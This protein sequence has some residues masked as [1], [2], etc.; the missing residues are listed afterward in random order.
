MQSYQHLMCYIIATLPACTLKKNYSNNIT[1]LPKKLGI[2]IQENK[3]AQP[4]CMQLAV[5]YKQQLISICVGYSNNN[6]TN[7]SL[8]Y[9]KRTK[10]G[11]NYFSYDQ[12][13]W[14][15]KP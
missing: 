14:S 6:M 12:D 1:M 10:M 2:E 7:F 13:I 3:I 11:H 8:T 4:Y 5:F 9:K 15:T